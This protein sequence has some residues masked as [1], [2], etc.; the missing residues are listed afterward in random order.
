MDVF[1]NNSLIIISKDLP[2]RTVKETSSFLEASYRPTY[3]LVY[4]VKE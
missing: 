3:Y 4:K 2:A 1:K